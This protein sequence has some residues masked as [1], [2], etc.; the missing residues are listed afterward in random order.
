[1]VKLDF[2]RG[3]A[4]CKAL[5]DETRAKIAHILSCG[6]LCACEIHEYFDLSQPTL[7]HH[8]AILVESGLVLARHEGKW[9]HYRLAT[10]TFE[11]LRLFLGVLSG[12]GDACLCKK[13][14]KEC[15]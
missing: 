4:L 8:L 15:T 7:S 1:V 12:G 10:E 5:G 14:R 6:E 9:V 2:G 11:E 3:A 13:K